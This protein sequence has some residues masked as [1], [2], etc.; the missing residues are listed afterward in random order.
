MRGHESIEGRVSY[1]GPPFNFACGGPGS[2]KYVVMS[3]WTSMGVT[4]ETPPFTMTSFQSTHGQVA[5]W[6][7]YCSSE[8]DDRIAS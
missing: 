3:L 2:R 7:E 5:V 4:M 1:P 8:T 6:Y